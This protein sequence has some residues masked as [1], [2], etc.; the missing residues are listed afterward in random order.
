MLLIPSAV[1]SLALLGSPA[2]FAGEVVEERSVDLTQTVSLHEIP[3]G[4]DLV[5][6]WVPVPSDSDWQRVTQFE[7]L[8]APAGWQVVRQSEGR[9]EFL[10]VEVPNPATESLAVTIKCRVSR[11][12]VQFPLEVHAPGTRIQPDAFS[13]YLDTDAPLMESSLKVK[14]MADQVCGAETDPT[15]Q[16]RLL[17]QA[18]ADAADHYSK[19]PTKPKCGRGAAEDCLTNKGGCCT[20]LHSLFIALA[21]ARGI[22]ARLQ[23]GY[24][25]LD[26]KA[27]KEVDPGYRCWIEFYSPDLGWVPTDIVACE[28]SA[29][30]T[31]LR[32][33][34]LSATKVWL[35]EGRSFELTP[36][37]SAGRVH[38]MICGFAEVD[39]KPVDVLQSH[40]GSKPS[41]LRRTIKFD[42]VSTTRTPGGSKL[43][44]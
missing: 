25:A 12:G 32:W 1:A 10:Y 2:T 18:V 36:T 16:A 24:R 29:G 27:G 31:E 20:D 19:D 35:W 34:S 43:P 15:V 17:M 6:L 41:N 33:G 44:D 9:G 23:F 39:G 30:G 11:Q 8:E 21:R 3:A 4:T 40:D 37:T 42:V 28:G 14:L 38:T 22:P 26:E 5:R 7:V 13:A